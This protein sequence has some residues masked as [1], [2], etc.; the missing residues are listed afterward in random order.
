MNHQRGMRAKPLLMEIFL[1][2]EN[3]TTKRA[4][5]IWEGFIVEKLKSVQQFEN[6]VAGQKGVLVLKHSLTCPISSAAFAEYNDF[7]EENTG[8][9]MYFLAVQE[10][11]DLS[12]YIAD[13]THVKHESPQA[14]LFMNE[15][16]VWHTSHWKITKKT[17]QDALKEYQLV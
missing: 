2:G 7:S 3:Q 15:A 12:N 5:D 17:L 9:N 11:R 16:V 4:G 6:A 14:I 10:A 13:K 8:V 1:L